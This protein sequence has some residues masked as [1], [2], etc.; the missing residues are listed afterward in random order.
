TILRTIFHR[1]RLLLL[2]I[3]L[4]SIAA[5]LSAW[6]YY[7][8]ATSKSAAEAE[9]E[10]APVTYSTDTPVEFPEDLPA[11]QWKGGQD[12]PKKI[13]IPSIEVDAFIQK[14]GIDQNNNIAVPTHLF[15]TG[16]F[17]ESARP[18]TTGL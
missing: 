2:G 14:V 17:I 1:K 12:D 3:I 8:A 18:G 16:W 6:K 13:T 4:I 5:T 15:V 10:G 11:Y 9:I 7:D